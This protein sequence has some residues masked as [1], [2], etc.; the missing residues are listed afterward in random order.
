MAGSSV[1]G[2]G[3]GVILLLILWTLTGIAWVQLSRKQGGLRV[4]ITLLSLLLTVALFLIPTDDG[5]SKRPGTISPD[6]LTPQDPYEVCT[7]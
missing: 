1:V 3:V 4:M 6:Q 2:L 5:K 7:M